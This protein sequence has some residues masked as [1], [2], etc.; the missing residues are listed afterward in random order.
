MPSVSLHH[1]AGPRPEP[2][3]RHAAAVAA[4]A[5]D[6][7]AVSSRG[8]EL[9]DLGEIYLN[10]TATLVPLLLRSHGAEP[11]AGPVAVK[12][13]ATF[14]EVSARTSVEMFFQLENENL[15]M[16]DEAIASG[17]G[18]H[19]H[20]RSGG[21][22]GGMLSGSGAHGCAS[23]GP[24]FNELFNSIGYVDEVAVPPKAGQAAPL[25]AVFVPALALSVKERTS[26]HTPLNEYTR[27]VSVSGVLDLA[28]AGG[29]GPLATGADSVVQIPIHARLCYSVLSTDVTEIEFD[30]CEPNRNYVREFTVWNRSE[31]PLWFRME[32]PADDRILE[33]RDYDTQDLFMDGERTVPAYGHVRLRLIFK[34]KSVG[35]RKWQL[36]VENL[37]NPDNTVTLA[38][39]TSV[40]AECHRKDLVI[41]N[42]DGDVLPSGSTLQF[43]DC[44]VG[45]PMKKTLRIQNTT[46][47]RD[48]RPPS[49]F[50]K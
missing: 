46:A 47:V 6:A 24:G 16:R 33:C 29:G 42:N 3:P 48:P 18:G 1:A 12:L 22:S 49:F 15:R 8:L 37:N 39:T 4:A 44:Y 27:M 31:I 35:Q 38:I 25:V 34:P 26:R 5:A 41:Q 14:E 45:M 23:G 20:G 13:R 50:R 32:L 7:A 10:D 11:E 19:E 30:E 40:T 21:S 36:F 17:N 2:R 9:L 28:V 43:G